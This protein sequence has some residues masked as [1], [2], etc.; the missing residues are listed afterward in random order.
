MRCASQAYRE[1]TQTSDL[2]SVLRV[3]V[4]INRIGVSGGAER[5]TLE[6]IDGLHGHGFEF[7]VFELWPVHGPGVTLRLQDAGIPV[8]VGPRRF[9]GRLVALRKLIR[10]TRPDVVHS[11]LFDADMAS[12]AA[13]A[14][15]RT[16]NLCSLVST[17][18]GSAAM[19]AARSPWRLQVVRVLDAAT[20]R[21]FVRRFHAVSDAVREHARTRLWLPNRRI[22]VVHR[23][24]PQSDW[25]YRQR[26]VEA[27]FGTNS[28]WRGMCLSC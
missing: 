12:R 23:G 9:P 27:V 18:Y 24:V 11:V 22:R 16:P 6:I 28:D 5:S 13:T 4:V 7:M 19:D 8:H 25:V 10:S 3:L 15:S 21:L 17:Q 20:G 1:M 14:C 2:P 26:T